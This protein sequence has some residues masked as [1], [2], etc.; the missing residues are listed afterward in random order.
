[1]SKYELVDTI[2]ETNRYTPAVC[3]CVFKSDLN[4]RSK[5][6]ESDRLMFLD[7]I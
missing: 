3:A 4:N 2:N 7:S 5:I 1:M 6:N